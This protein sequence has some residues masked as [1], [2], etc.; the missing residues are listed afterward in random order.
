MEGLHPT[1]IFVFF[2][3]GTL[4]KFLVW[5]SEPHRGCHGKV[6]TGLCFLW[7]MGSYTL[8]AIATF[9]TGLDSVRG[10][11]SWRRKKVVGGLLKLRK[12]TVS[13]IMSVCPSTCLDGTTRLPLEVLHKNLLRDLIV[14]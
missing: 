7:S 6:V 3:T 10:T 8:V 11:L 4:W 2:G 12:A 14:G 9:I 5:M 13:S 1:L